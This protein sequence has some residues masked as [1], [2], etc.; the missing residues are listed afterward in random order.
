MTFLKIEL[1]SC[2]IGRSDYKMLASRTLTLCC[3]ARNGFSLSSGVSART[4]RHLAIFRVFSSTSSSPPP[5]IDVVATKPLAT[6]NPAPPPPD[7]HDDH[8]SKVASRTLS[9]TERNFITPVRAMQDFLLKSNELAGLRNTMRR[10]PH[11]D[12][13][14]M[15]VYWR[16]DVE[17]R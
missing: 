1:N 15:S 13:P 14:P 2:A 12:E 4:G 8:P 9:S 11:A 16:R 10:F 17:Q 5:K 7:L 3:G 6:V